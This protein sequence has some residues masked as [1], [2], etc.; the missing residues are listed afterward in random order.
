MPVTYNDDQHP[1]D[2]ADTTL[3]SQ[4]MA[5]SM[6]FQE[7]SGFD[8]NFDF[9]GFNFTNMDYFDLGNTDAIDYEKAFMEAALSVGMDENR[10]D[11]FPLDSSPLVWP[12]YPSQPDDNNTVM[13]TG[14]SLG[15]SSPIATST[16]SPIIVPTPLEPNDAPARRRPTKRRKKA[17]E[18]SE[19]NILPEGLQ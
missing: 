8:V 19:A 16:S 15:C 1:L 13:S 2:I 5:Y 3:H 18:V 9:D 7:N 12:P 14:R 6:A 10:T 17:N 11:G 4:S